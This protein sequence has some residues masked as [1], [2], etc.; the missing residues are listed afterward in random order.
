MW[1]V[2]LVGCAP[3][4]VAPVPTPEAVPPPPALER[5]FRGVWIATVANID[6]PSRPG[7]P[8][9][10]QQA[11]L[12]ALLDRAAALGLNAVV[13]QVR[14]HGDALYDSPYE[15]WS[16]YLT[17]EQGRP[18]EPFYDPLAFAIEEA[19]RR[20]LELHAWFNPY[21]AHHPA[22]RSTIAP[23]HI[24]RRRP[25][26]VREYGEYLWMDPG[27]PEVAEHSLRVVLDVVR[28]YDVDGVHF[29]DYFYPYPIDDAEG[30]RVDF[31]DDASWGRAVAAGETRSRADWRR[32]NVDA[33][34]RRV[35]EAVKAERPEVKVGISPFGIWRPGHPEVVRG[36]DAYEGLYADSRR[37]L[38]E[39]WADY[40]APQLYWALASEGQPF[41][42]L[43][44]W[45]EAQNT[46]GRHLWPGLYTSRVGFDDARGW[47]PEEVLAQV[48]R[49][50]QSDAATGHIH[51]SM[52]WLR[53]GV[54]PVGDDLA[55]ETYRAPAL[56]PA[57]PWLGDAR[58][59]TPA[60]RVE[61]ASG[62]PVLAVRPAEGER[63][64]LWAVRFRHGA[65]WTTAVVPGWR[66]A[67]PLPRDAA[68]RLPDE[69]AVSAVNR[70]GHESAVVR[71]PVPR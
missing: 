56:V 64:W 23:D 65:A 9:A 62:G 19:H 24:A 52:R 28:R 13:F 44:T 51:F 16:E 60:A 61:A 57:S 33:F 5:E 68:G 66:Q 14:P 35:Y 4:A 63:A 40:F 36:F 69:V 47:G 43:L 26:L 15:P 22:A 71:V 18:P 55:R 29:D 38:R 1:L 27:E 20:G 21:R 3:R 50:R 2:G 32:A 49:V 37:W 39:G 42:P 6:W 58:P 30:R 8:V 48:A 45:W 41:G 7:L 67:Y 34:I 70:L 59:G 12:R 11:E 10:E 17:G 53:A 46:A 25:D 31:P 54:N